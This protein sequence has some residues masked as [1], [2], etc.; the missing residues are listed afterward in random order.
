MHT[1][2]S[3]TQP[4]MLPYPSAGWCEVAYSTPLESRLWRE[5][6]LGGGS[7]LS[8]PIYARSPPIAGGFS[9]SLPDVPFHCLL[10]RVDGAVVSVVEHWELGEV[11]DNA[12]KLHFEAPLL[13]RP[14]WSHNYRLGIVEAIV[15]T[16]KN[17]HRFQMPFMPPHKG[18]K[19]IDAL[20]SRFTA[21]DG[22]S[23]L[24]ALDYF[25]RGAGSVQVVEDAGNGRV[26]IGWTSGRIT[27]LHFL[28][29]D[30]L[31]ATVTELS[32]SYYKLFGF[33][34]A[35]K[36]SVMALSALETENDTLIF[37][38]YEDKKLS[39]WS[40]R[41]KK[42]IHTKP[43][44]VQARNPQDTVVIGYRMQIFTQ[45][46][47]DIFKLILF[48]G[49]HTSSL[50][51]IYN[52]QIE[53]DAFELTYETGH[54]SQETKLSDLVVTHNA[55]WTQ[56]D[57]I[58]GTT[59]QR[60]PF[61]SEACIGLRDAAIQTSAWVPVQTALPDFVTLAVDE[62]STRI[63]G[64]YLKTIVNGGYFTHDQIQRALKEFSPNTVAF[65]PSSTDQLREALLL[66]VTNR[67]QSLQGLE[68]T[69]YGDNAKLQSSQWN[70]LLNY[71]IKLWKEDNVPMG[72]YVHPGKDMIFALKSNAVTVV[73][74]ADSVEL[75]HF[76]PLPFRNI[77]NAISL[78]IGE[79]RL[80]SYEEDLML[81]VHPSTLVAPLVSDLLVSLHARKT[82]AGIVQLKRPA[83]ALASLLNRLS[84][85]SALNNS[86][87]IGTSLSSDMCALIAAT[88]TQ[89]VRSRF[90]LLSRLLVLLGFMSKH[91]KLGK[92]VSGAE[93]IQ[94]LFDRTQSLLQRYVLLF[95][96]SALPYLSPGFESQG[97]SKFRTEAAAMALPKLSTL[98]EMFIWETMESRVLD[99][100][101]SHTLRIAGIQ[102]LKSLW[103]A[104]GLVIFA[105]FLFRHQ[106]YAY[107]EDLVN[108]L[109]WGCLEGSYQEDGKGV[110]LYL[111]GYSRLKMG[112]PRKATVSFVHALGY[113]DELRRE[114]SSLGIRYEDR[115]GENFLAFLVDHVSKLLI[116]ANYNEGA[117]YIAHHATSSS[118]AG[119][120][121]ASE[122][123]AASVFTSYLRST[124]YDH[125]YR[126]LASYPDVQRQMEGVRHYI[127]VVCSNGNERSIVHGSGW[128]WGNLGQL[129]H[130]ALL[131]MARNQDVTHAPNYYH[132]VYSYHIHRSHYMQAAMAMW[133][134]AQRAY[135]EAHSAILSNQLRTIVQAYVACLSA[136][137]L[138]PTHTPDCPPRTTQEIHQRQKRKR[139]PTAEALVSDSDTAANQEQ[140][141]VLTIDEVE[142]ALALARANLVYAEYSPTSSLPLRNDK[143]GAEA[144][145]K[146]LVE[147]G[148]IESAASLALIYKL[149]LEFLIETLTSHALLRNRAG[150]I[151]VEKSST[152]WLA[153]YTAE[154]AGALS[155]S[156]WE[157]VR[158]YVQTYSNAD[159]NFQ[160]H[161]TVAQCILEANAQAVL[162]PWLVASFKEHKPAGLVGLYMHYGAL[163]DAALV[164]LEL[165][166]DQDS[167][168]THA[169]HTAVAYAPYHLA[170]GLLQHLP[171]PQRQAAGRARSRG[172]AA[173]P[174]QLGTPTSTVNTEL[175]GR[176][177][178]AMQQRMLRMSHL[179]LSPV[180]DDA[181]AAL[182]GGSPLYNNDMFSSSD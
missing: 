64:W 127:G 69:T 108:S 74:E 22:R 150:A 142:K 104:G 48:F 59:L 163:E 177:H 32:E 58:H 82:E 126:V 109:V 102:L 151:P 125:A 88:T 170:E 162:P 123:L 3:S 73:R 95:S 141:W 77:F 90:S 2:N 181:G 11:R 136:L 105:S 97:M 55:L 178:H 66:A 29:A 130:K 17:V 36:P 25:V 81:F 52:G 23:S 56:W 27:V 15:I 54:S 91:P 147:A 42:C 35:T 140:E 8:Q 61:T 174:H 60:A 124:R 115:D 33:T 20:F 99:S 120:T 149:S 159:N 5:V 156:L 175:H 39:V 6:W 1:D 164:L 30:T 18:V 24:R 50:F 158:W 10:W 148:F 38:V 117:A 176:L 146:R 116:S 179:L 70:S 98:L 16:E 113:A 182:R 44:E 41:S 49:F 28:D 57:S 138:F 153:N 87:S 155:T 46:T 96:V 68:A 80:I 119:L 133:E 131:D 134:L 166:E 31:D 143:D 51:Q 85:T 84:D 145:F 21:D 173:E 79:S 103:A 137:R 168:P 167:I 110:L 34:S 19:Q 112:D 13:G 129:V 67:V 63:D 89:L 7:L 93:R 4:P 72:L 106:Q 132:L 114:G 9:L 71:C 47:S 14:V 122:E 180:A 171:Q 152:A 165:L 101:I 154:S 76:L 111:Q 169:N 172:V 107:C 135:R 83:S 94:Q 78:A 100:P 92:S 139:D 160:Y 161:H 75:L 37:A 157:E 121:W 12:I 65:S 62:S 40:L 45:P 86:K 26:M 118:A 43:L 144:T 53:D 128:T